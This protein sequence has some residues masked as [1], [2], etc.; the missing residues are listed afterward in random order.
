[1]ELAEGQ[2][3]ERLLGQLAP[4]LSRTLVLCGY[5][6]RTGV[7]CEHPFGSVRNNLIKPSD[8]MESPKRGIVCYL[9][10]RGESGA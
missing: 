7:V 8:S 9:S 3:D 10:R 6:F 4:G 5:G 1:M 2:V